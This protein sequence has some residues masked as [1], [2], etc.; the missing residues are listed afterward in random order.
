MNKRMHALTRA[1]VSIW[2]DDLSRAR[3]ASGN[4]VGLIRDYQ[5]SAR[6]AIGRRGDRRLDVRGCGLTGIG[7]ARS[8]WSPDRG[9]S[10]R[11]DSQLGRMKARAVA[12]CSRKA[13]SY[14][15]PNHPQCEFSETNSITTFV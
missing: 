15:P 13:A 3:L 7:T 5:V 2:L 8:E 4:L 1:G 11:A 12:W 14:G 6:G 10:V 9:Q